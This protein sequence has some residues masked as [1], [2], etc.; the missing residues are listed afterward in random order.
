MPKY[1]REGRYVPKLYFASDIHGSDTCWKKFLASAVY[2]K[3]DILVLGGDMTG[4]AIV[5]LVK[6]G[7]VHRAALLGSSYELESES[8][9]Q[10]FEKRIRSRGYYPVRMEE[11]ERDFYAGD[12]EA[13]DRRF[14]KE[15]CARIESWMSLAEERLP[16]GIPC[17]LCPGN[18]DPFEVDAI[19]AESSAVLVGEGRTIDLGGFWLAST[20]WTTPTPWNTCREESEEA[21]GLRIRTMPAGCA[22]PSRLIFN[23]HCPPFG[24]GLDDAPE[25]GADLSVKN[26]GQST[27][28]VGSAA[29]RDAI[30][31]Y[32]PLVSL[33]GH[34]HEA[35]GVSRIGRTLAVNPGSL[36]EQGVLQG[37]L[38]ELDAKKG[39]RSYI[40]TT[41]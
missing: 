1:L 38:L 24:S 20:G 21:L 8:A 36:Y 25:L 37:A 6:T 17:I 12:R 35:K 13:L 16:R 19:L 3:A 29:V 11:D 10:D 14:I 39:L 15:V 33:H 2:Y 18:D 22:D 27:V 4:K 7:S 28:P 23:F 32:K 31:E 26:A 34:I 41:G 40:L 5:P 9:V 30:V